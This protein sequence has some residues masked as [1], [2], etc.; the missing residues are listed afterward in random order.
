MKTSNSQQT[1]SQQQNLKSTPQA[2]HSKRRQ[3]DVDYDDENDLE[4]RSII[5]EQTVEVNDDK[6]SGRGILKVR[7]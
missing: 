3:P 2:L 1:I 7:F 6:V 5:D 4:G